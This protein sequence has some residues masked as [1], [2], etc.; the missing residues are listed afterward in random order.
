MQRGYRIHVFFILFLLTCSSAFAQLLME[1]FDYKTGETLTSHGWNVLAESGT[2]PITATSTGLTFSNYP[3]SSTTKAAL[4]DNVG[5]DVYRTFPAQTSGSV[6]V[7]FLLNVTNTA[8]SYF[9]YFASD[10]DPA[11]GRGRVSIRFPFNGNGDYALGL[12]HSSSGIQ[13]STSFDLTYGTTYVVVLKYTFVPGGS[14]NDEVR[15]YVFD[16]SF[17]GKEPSTP[18]TGPF[19]GIDAKNI[20]AIVLRQFSDSHVMSVDGIRVSTA[21]NEALPV[22]LTTFSYRPTGSG[23]ELYWRTATESNN[24]GFEVQ[25]KQ[26]NRVWEK[27]GF[28]PGHG[29]TIQPQSYRYTDETVRNGQYKYRLKQIDTD[30]HFELSRILTVDL[31]PPAAFNLAQN[32]PNP[33]NPST[34]INYSIAEPA[35]VE[36]AIF[37]LL[38][39]TVRTLVHEKQ[40]AG[41][42]SLIWN[43][44]DDSGL[45][46]PSGFYFC[47]LMIDGKPLATRKMALLK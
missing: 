3:A 46:M 32:Y 35:Q 28:V 36:L 1:D 11:T 10:S 27:V 45:Q 22:E 4:M 2:N 13:G 39:E 14:T 41:N 15:M 20:G 8:Q 6:Y 31:R 38:G 44:Q 17:P 26:G 7:S 23:V 24:Y 43:G 19:T 5:E 30:G 33:F 21:W 42:Y 40:T 37:D 18:E 34:S 29:T 12:S 9:L 25:R 47:R 16:S